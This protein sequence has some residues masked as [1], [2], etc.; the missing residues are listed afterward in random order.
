MYKSN[1]NDDLRAHYMGVGMAI[2]AGF[3]I[4]FSILL[5]FV[6]KHPGMIG[7]GA[8]I[9]VSIGIAIGEG[10]Y[11]RHKDRERRR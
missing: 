9:G 11:Q 7:V 6:L 8:A 1:D 4:V 3:G 2:G 5:V 10:L